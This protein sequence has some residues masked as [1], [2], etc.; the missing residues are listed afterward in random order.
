[1]KL[2]LFQFWS[3]NVTF[4]FGLFSVDTYREDEMEYTLLGFQYDKEDRVLEID[5]FWKCFEFKPFMKQ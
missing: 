5:L 3:G 4:G 2:S 1:M